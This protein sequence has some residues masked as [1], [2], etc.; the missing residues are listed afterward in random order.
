MKS[1]RNNTEKNSITQQK[2]RIFIG[3]GVTLGELKS[4]D[5]RV[6]KTSVGRYHIQM[7]W[8]LAISVSRTQSQR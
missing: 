2:D 6:T 5:F 1:N 4:V 7:A 3:G 8:H